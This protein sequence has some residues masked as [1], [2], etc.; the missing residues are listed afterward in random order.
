M[1]DLGV[2]TTML[3]SSEE[4][5]VDKTSVLFGIRTI[6][7]DSTH[8]IR[9]NGK[10]VKLKGGCLHHDNGLLGAVSIYDA[11]YR[12]IKK[13][14]DQGFNLVRCAHNPP[15]SAFLDACDQLGMYVFN[16]AFDAW[17]IAKQPGD[18]NQ[19]FESDWK[20]DIRAYMLRDR[21]RASVI[22]WSTGNEI[23]ERGGL[24]NGYTLALQLA[25]YT[26]SL[27]SSR[28]VTNGFCSYWSALDDVSLQEQLRKQ[29]Q[30][31]QQNA[32]ALLSDSFL[33]D[34]SE[35]FVSMLDVV[36]YNYLDSHYEADGERYP[37]RVIL[38]TE[39]FPM[40]IDIVWDKVE[41]LPYVIGDCTWTAFD[42]IG[43]SGIGQS[44]FFEPDDPV[45]QNRMSAATAL[46]N[47]Y[48]WR[49]GNDADF[50]INGNLM[51]QGVYRSIVW[52]SNATGLF[53]QDPANF[54][55]EE[56]I[57][58]WGWPAVTAN[59]NW[60]AKE[61]A[62]VKLVVYSSAPEVELLLNGTSFGRKSSGKENRYT[63]TFEV[64]Y[65]PGTLEVISLNGEEV[66]SAA[67]L[68]T[69]GAPAKIRL[70]QE[71]AV[72]NNLRYIH[73]EIVDAQEN[74]VPDAEVALCASLEGD[75]AL[76]GFGSSNPITTDNYT[77]GKASSY[78][79]RAMSII[80]L[81]SD[82]AGAKLTVSAPGFDDAFLHI[83]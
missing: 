67:K 44:A 37:E 45:F 32:P 20:D 31:M 34:R 4:S 64:P 71:P 25:E 28:P 60:N 57:S 52:G 46:K 39:S 15:S 51:P 6:Q 17:G 1:T 75:A 80:R 16:E 49:L 33:E 74:I 62:L 13:L 55:K 66:I 8:G 3:K 23:F 19:F 65:A 7:T 58:M 81:N 5:T 73:V 53:V 9:I 56:L 11:E 27:D 29:V 21:S 79:G 69:T 30:A 22:F 82:F 70:Y 14:K 40:N 38:G 47:H 36:G 61:G 48:P 42:Y 59:W 35:P 10:S 43:E 12:K 78:H 54:G 2:F 76:A 68:T 77:A 18:Y 41:K 72:G 50:D 63:A 26:K 83:Q 24:N